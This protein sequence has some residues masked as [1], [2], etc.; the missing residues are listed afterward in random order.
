MKHITWICDQDHLQHP[1]ISQA[2]NAAFEEGYF[3]TI[4]DRADVTSDAPYC[5]VRTR[6]PR[7]PIKIFG[8]TIKRSTKINLLLGWFVIL[9]KAFQHSAQLYVADLPST[10]LIAWVAARFKGSKLLY[11]PYELFGEQTT[12]VTSFSKK[13]ERLLLRNCVDG[14]ITQN[15]FRADVYKLEKGCRVEPILVRNTKIT[16]DC[17]FKGGLRFA[18]SLQDDARIVVYEGHLIQGRSL[19]ILVESM[20]YLVSRNVH[21]VFVGARTSWWL[22]VVEPKIKKYKL[23]NSIHLHPYVESKNIVDYISDAD[24][25]VLIY[26]NSCKNNIYC[27]P[28]KLS[29]YISARLPIVAPAYPPLVEIVGKYDIGVLFSSISPEE[30]AKAIDNALSNQ[31][32]VWQRRLE[33]AELSYNWNVDRKVLLDQFERL[34]KDRVSEITSH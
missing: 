24:I 34:C 2:V 11:H 25:G 8:K 20:N 29:D 16:K 22:R 27:A 14:L 33:L 12:R 23:Q 1:F 21:L 15:R 31:K 6:F 5:H 26:D 30:I 10:L 4:V 13:I 17:S 32:D 3:V 7:A 9:I 19:E 28:G 18:L